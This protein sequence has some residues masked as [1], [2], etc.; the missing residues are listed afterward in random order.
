[1]SASE[2]R[3]TGLE[4]AIALHKA[5]KLA[6]A[7]RLYRAH[8]AAE[9][10][11]ALALSNLGHILQERGEHEAA[12]ELYERAIALK[13]R[14]AAAH[15]Y[16]GNAL[17]ALGRTSEARE[18]LDRAIAL[19]PKSV[20][21]PAGLAALRQR[22]GDVQDAVRYWQRAL[23]A[24][25]AR[26]DVRQN[27]ALA[28][29]E[30]G[31]PDQAVAVMQ[32]VMKAEPSSPVAHSNLAAVFS[33]A[34]QFEQAI[35][36]GRRATLLG[37]ENADAHYNL[38]V[39]LIDSGDH[40]AGLASLQQ[41]L[42]IKPDHLDALNLMGM[43][44]RRM[45]EHARALDFFRRA[46][47]ADPRH[48]GILV[49]I[50][51]TLL[52]EGRLEE[53]LAVYRHA[54][55]ID[56]KKVDVLVNLG[57][58]LEQLERFEEALDAYRLAIALEP[59]NAVAHFN[60]GLAL[61]TLGR[62][63]EGWPEYEWR[64]RARPPLAA[65]DLS[66]SSAW[67]GEPLA[68]RRILVLAEQGSGDSIQF[69][70]YLPMLRA[71]GAR[72]TFECQPALRRLIEESDLAD[73]VMT[74]DEAL[75][76]H[77]FHAPLLSLPGLLGTRREAI[78]AAIPYLAVDGH[79]VERRGRQLLAL[80]RPLIGIAWQGNPQHK[81]D[82]RRSIPLRM[83]R[84]A[85]AST[86]ASLVSLQVGHGSEQMGELPQTERPY[87]PF[88]E[89]SAR[90]FVSTAAVV[91]NMDAIVSIDSAVAHLA[92][93]LGRRVFVLLP[94]VGDWRWLQGREDSPWY[95]TMRLLRQHRLG[96]WSYVFA[97]L[98]EALGGMR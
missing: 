33:R 82:R 55:T 91:A 68:G 79:E 87:D 84:G 24:A 46:E 13:P 40:A 11:A 81:G 3:S 38:A 21:G 71:A 47:N 8:L 98:A 62:F 30:A 59:E 76:D 48:T 64:Q 89:E 29:S 34:G 74:R 70:R 93:A 32:P 35:A 53:A 92:G 95:P 86:G 66:Q 60:L 49:N 73:T 26:N 31:D 97:R 27:L 52:E 77:D 14:F 51:A 7:E 2:V 9:P 80:Q 56:D 15:A 72:V 75:P 96:D 54:M 94:H 78:P 19:D 42:A 90:D 25:P 44:H 58:T 5:G 22:Q 45:S 37:P 6:E 10:R 1:M 20:E 85:L 39:A 28:L 61:L 69:C 88:T 23:E 57:A 65:R 18:A 12:V 36:A 63:K 83:M 67:K 41:V 16:R 17:A 4:A 50:G 43:H